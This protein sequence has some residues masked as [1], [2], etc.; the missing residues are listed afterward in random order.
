VDINTV[1]VPWESQSNHWWNETCANIIEHFGLPG[2]KYTTEVSADDMR[3]FF[4]D[5]RDALMCRILISECI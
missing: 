2:G 1:T 5:D 4:K 3:F